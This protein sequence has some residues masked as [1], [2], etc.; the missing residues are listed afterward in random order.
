MPQMRCGD[1]NGAEFHLD[2]HSRITP[3]SGAI[4]IARRVSAGKSARDVRLIITELE[5]VWL[6]KKRAED[7]GIAS[8]QKRSLQQ[9]RDY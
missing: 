6:G 5:R 7:N 9:R 2:V 3:R 8:Q 4:D 1:S